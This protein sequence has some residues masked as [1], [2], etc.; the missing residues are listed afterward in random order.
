MDI[1]HDNPEVK[2]VKFFKTFI[3]LYFVEAVANCIVC[4]V[5]YQWCCAKKQVNV[6]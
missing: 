1:Y 3:F 6:S 5:F 2:S 4:A